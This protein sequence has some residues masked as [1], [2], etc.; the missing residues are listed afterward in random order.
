MFLIIYPTMK[1]FLDLLATNYTINILLTVENVRPCNVK[2]CINGLILFNAYSDSDIFI[3]HK[4]PLLEPVDIEVHHNGAYVKSLTF[5]SW[6]SRPQHGMENPGLWK[7]STQ[8][9]VFYRW[10][11]HSTG[12]GWL[13]EP[14]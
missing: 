7:F 3:E 14:V 5:D 6:E 12:Q 2:I 1:N 9:L 10:K 13:L 4:I 11:H 8:G